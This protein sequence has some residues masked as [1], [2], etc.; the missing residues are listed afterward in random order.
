[1]KK[2]RLK[3]VVCLL[4][5][6]ILLSNIMPVVNAV[7]NELD[8]SD[9]LENTIA[10]NDIT[11]NSSDNSN[12][13]QN[14]MN[15]DLN[16]ISYFEVLLAG[17]LVPKDKSFTY[18]DVNEIISNNTFSQNGLWVSENSRS[19]IINLLN[20]ISN[21][22]Y[23]IKDNGFLEID[24]NNPKNE[25]NQSAEYL[26]YTEKIK[27]LIDNQESVTVLGIE[28]TYKYLNTYDNEI[29]D[30]IIEDDEYALQFKNE[31][32]N[33]N[34][35]DIIV[36][37]AKIYNTENKL[38][39]NI[40]LANN[41]LESIFNDDEDFK[42]FIEKQDKLEN[43][44]NEQ[45]IVHKT[46]EKEVKQENVT[47][48]NVKENV[49]ENVT[50]KNEEITKKNIFDDRVSEDIFKSVL[51]GMIT[52]NLCYDNVNEIIQDEITRNDGIWISKDS[53]ENFLK[54]LNRHTIYTY[55]VDSEGFLVCD[56]IMKNNP[57]LDFLE[58]E[59]TEVDI[60]IKNIL[61]LKKFVAIQITDSYP[62]LQ[63]EELMISDIEKSKN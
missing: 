45:D 59:E 39:S 2:I 1:M 22:N 20:A 61:N 44:E 36:L 35:S 29:L 40:T 60:E 37:N 13:V 15:D 63:N 18:L 24:E 19:Y 33:S 52:K 57:E 6:I 16:E 42:D 55:S 28:E 23:I 41:L 9:N 14:S 62:I 58:P 46:E 25:E 10:S 50:E 27:E 32:N 30:M 31:N 49:N 51:A 26:Y 3:I 8:L 53:R 56:N 43:E 47:E 11:E 5:L 21:D 34:I 12:I 48:E 17:I 54:F 4:V 7:Y 38:D